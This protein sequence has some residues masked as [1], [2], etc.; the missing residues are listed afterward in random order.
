VD[1]QVRLDHLRGGH[2]RSGD[3]PQVSADGVSV[4]T[5]SLADR[6]NKQAAALRDEYKAAQIGAEIDITNVLIGH[7]RDDSIRPLRFGVGMHDNPG[8]GI[9]DYGGATFDPFADANSTVG[10]WGEQ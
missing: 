4:D 8:A 3:R 9:Q 10:S 1:A 7:G 6:F 5:S 2:R